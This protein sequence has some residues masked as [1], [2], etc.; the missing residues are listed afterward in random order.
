MFVYYLF[1]FLFLSCLVSDDDEAEHHDSEMSISQKLS[2]YKKRKKNGVPKHWA[3][4]LVAFDPVQFP[5]YVPQVGG[6]WEKGRER[7]RETKRETKRERERDKKK[8]KPKLLTKPTT[9]KPTK[10][11][12]HR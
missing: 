5:A 4:W 12:T 1:M 11:L 10:K 2:K 6:V 9:Q 8:A 3:D 7:E